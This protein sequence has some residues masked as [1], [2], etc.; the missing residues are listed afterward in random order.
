[1]DRI[2]PATQI[3]P[4]IN[5]YWWISVDSQLIYLLSVP[6]PDSRFSSLQTTFPNTLQHFTKCPLGG[7]LPNSEL[8]FPFPLLLMFLWSSKSSSAHHRGQ[9][10]TH[11]VNR[12]E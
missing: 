8:L 6:P 7:A 10:A 3:Q 4:L 11:D 12:Q 2:P 5:S 1:M 9:E